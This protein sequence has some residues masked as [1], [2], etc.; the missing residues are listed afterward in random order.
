[1]TINFYT[2][3]S[4]VLTPFKKYIP[5]MYFIKV[6]VAPVVWD[7]ARC[8]LLDKDKNEIEVVDSKEL[9]DLALL[10]NESCFSDFLNNVA[11]NII[12]Q[13]MQLT[14]LLNECIEKV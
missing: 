3:V 9:T 6:E 1:M 8:T 14:E 5:N 12:F 11:G 10:W 7:F 13:N 2:G 4:E